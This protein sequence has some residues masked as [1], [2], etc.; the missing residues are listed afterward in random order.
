M[1]DGNNNELCAYIF[2]Y[3]HFSMFNSFICEALGW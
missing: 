2:H 3:F 1:K